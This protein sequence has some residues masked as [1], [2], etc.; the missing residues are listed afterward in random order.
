M[1]ESRY[2]ELLG[3]LLDGELSDQQAAEFAVELRSQPELQRDL[4][5]HLVLWEVWSQECCPDRTAASFHAAWQTRLAAEAESESFGRRVHARLA[6]EE[7]SGRLPGWRAL[8]SRWRRPQWIAAGALAVLC[9]LALALWWGGSRPRLPRPANSLEQV[10]TIAGEAVCP[11]CTLHESQQHSM[12]IRTMPGAATKIV[13]LRATNELAR[14][15]PKFCA[16]PAPVQ[17][18]GIAQQEGAKQ[19]LLAKTIEVSR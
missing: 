19:I 14:L 17:A 15:Q 16:G 2:Q 6:E 1:T 9:L 11:M 7:L 12:A 4:R 13:Y 18:T 8:W 10:V 5:T 3:L